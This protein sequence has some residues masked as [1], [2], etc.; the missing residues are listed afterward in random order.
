MTAVVLEIVFWYLL[1]SALDISAATKLVPAFRSCS[2]L[3]RYFLLSFRVADDTGYT[4]YYAA[5]MTSVRP[6]ATLVDSNHNLLVHQKVEIYTRQD[7]S[8]SK[9]ATVVIYIN[10]W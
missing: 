8:M 3:F 7:R 4:G 1:N 10:Y 2:V 9:Q 6:S 5:S